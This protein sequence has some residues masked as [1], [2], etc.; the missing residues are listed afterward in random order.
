[1]KQCRLVLPVLL[2][3]ILSGEL[4][5]Q[6]DEAVRSV[7]DA[8]HGA[9]ASG[10]STTALALL[11]PDVRILESGGVETFEEYRSGH[12]SGDIAFAAAVPRERSEIEVVVEGNVAWAWST[13]TSQGE[14]RGREI[15]SE[16]AELAV[17]RRMEGVWRIVAIH[18]SSRRR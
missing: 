11:H 16:G 2:L 5:A 1:M 6:D 15:V 12:L 7:I 9:L 14:Y 4:Q 8:Y 17:L 13:S 3:L 18:W 10:D